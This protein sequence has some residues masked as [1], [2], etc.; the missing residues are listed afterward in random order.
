MDA[1][2]KLDEENETSKGCRGVIAV[3]TLQRG[4]V[5]GRIW[6]RG[7]RIGRGDGKDS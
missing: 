6:E 5:V 3:D 7:S 1:L 4:Q 2:D